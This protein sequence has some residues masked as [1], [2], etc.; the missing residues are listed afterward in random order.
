MDKS[1]S[2]YGQVGGDLVSKVMHLRVSDNAGNSTRHGAIIFSRTLSP[3]GQLDELR[4]SQ[5]QFF[6]HVTPCRIRSLSSYTSF[7]RSSSCGMSRCFLYWFV[8]GRGP[9]PSPNT[10]RGA[11]SDSKCDKHVPPYIDYQFCVMFAKSPVKP[12]SYFRR[13]VVPPIP[14]MSHIAINLSF[15]ITLQSDVTRH[16]AE[17]Y[18]FFNLGTTWVWVVDATARSL[19]PR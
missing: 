14:F 9:L 3:W 15:I 5:R 16:A 4:F 11:K 6:W 13:F 17:L 19:H 18:S 10:R 8:W 2:E 1:G 7:G 12:V